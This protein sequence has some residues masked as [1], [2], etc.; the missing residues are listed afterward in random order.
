M[1]KIILSSLAASLILATATVSPQAHA[2]TTTGANKATATWSSYCNISS[3]NVNF[4]AY[5]PGSAG[6]TGKYGII[7]G[8]TTVT[9]MCTHKTPYNIYGETY[10]SDETWHMTGATAGNTDVLQ[11]AAWLASDYYS[12]WFGQGYSGTNHIS[13]TG[14]G[15]NQNY[16]IYFGIYT[17]DY[18]TP[19]SYSDTYTLT[20]SY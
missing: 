20:L 17:Q 1:K 12:S 8:A 19:D 16:T 14:T 5:T 11:Y 7:P 3:T 2:G 9:V 18:V 6:R 15:I 4:G 10:L 13:G